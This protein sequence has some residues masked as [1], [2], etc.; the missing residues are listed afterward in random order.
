MQFWEACVFLSHVYVSF[1]NLHNSV[2]TKNEAISLQCN[3]FVL[4]G[5]HELRQ[6][7]VRERVKY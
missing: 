2:K 4:R 1:L 5:K 6:Q 7:S 3:Y